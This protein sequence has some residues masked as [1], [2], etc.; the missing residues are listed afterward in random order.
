MMRIVSL[1]L[2]AATLCVN[3]C[4][5]EAPVKIPAPAFDQ[6]AIAGKLQTAVVAGGCFWGVQGVYQHLKGVKSVLSGYAGGGASS[7]DYESVSA[8]DSGHAESVQIVYDPA[9]VTYGQILQVFFSVAHDPT[10]LNRQGPDTGTQYRSAIFYTSDAQKK[11]AEGYIAQLDQAGVYPSRIVTR[12]NP[13][14]GFYEAESYHQDYLINHPTSA[15]IAYNDLPKVRN[16]QSTLPAL[17]VAEP[18]TVS[19]SKRA[20]VKAQTNAAPPAPAGSGAMMMAAAEKPAEGG[21]MMSAQ[22]ATGPSK[23]EGPLPPLTGATGWLNSA[24][25]TPASLRGKVVVVDFWAYSCINCL[26]AMPYVNAWY[27]HYKDAGLVVLGVHSPE[28]AFEKDIDNVRAAVKKFDIQYPVALDNEMAIWKA[29]NN[30]FW[31]AHYFVDAKGQIRGHHFGEGKYA[32]S[33]REIRRLLTEAG[34]KDLPDPLDDAAGEGVGAPA[35]TANVASP[36]TYVGYA[37]AEN[38]VS[39]GAFAR[40]AKKTYAV[41]KALTLNQWALGGPWQVAREH[42]RL[43]GTPGRIAFRFKARD[44]HLVLGP[45]AAGK[46]V[47]FRVT[48]GGAPPKMDAGMDV[49]ANGNGVVREHRLYQLI[50]EKGPVSEQ[51]FVIEFLD[52]GVDAYS[53]TFG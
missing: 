17:Y 3:A 45:A 48:L 20:G 24:P 50:R 36:E 30:K 31:P 37:R 29:F 38:F 27:R 18:V 6:P 21:A 53:F 19:Q 46:P 9:Q 33:E 52:P 49:D 5:S 42:A 2:L 28:F 43:D 7:A 1:A 47:R 13:L 25:L 8:G 34:A 11:I 51:E 14:K 35:D 40:D 15:Y 12:V 4:G 16:F 23:T 22:G 32:K 44:L 10:Q 26:R 39:P 41:P